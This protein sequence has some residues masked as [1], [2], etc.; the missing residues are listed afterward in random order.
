MDDMTDRMDVDS[1]PSL[2]GTH[3]NDHDQ[4]IG[5]ARVTLAMDDEEDLIDISK[6]QEEGFVAV[7]HESLGGRSLKQTPANK[8]KVPLVS[9]PLL[10]SQLP[11]CKAHNGEGTESLNLLSPVLE[12]ERQ[13]AGTSRYGRSRSSLT[14]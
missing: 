10:Q 3:L 13:P 8:Q 9:A 5:R 12:P 14:A 7:M 6:P 11:C 2:D 1:D 4:G